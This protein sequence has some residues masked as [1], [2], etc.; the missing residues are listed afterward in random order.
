MTGDLGH[1]H[2]VASGPH[3]VGQTAVAE[4]VSREAESGLG[5]DR[6]DDEVGL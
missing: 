5:A 4:H 6:A 2:H 3:Q 1:Q